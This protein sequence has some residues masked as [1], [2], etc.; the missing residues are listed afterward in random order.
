[1]NCEKCKKSII[2]IEDE[3]Y[4]HQCS[5]CSMTL[6]RQCDDTTDILKWFEIEDVDL[7][8]CGIC[9]TILCEQKIKKAIV[10]SKREDTKLEKDLHSQLY[11]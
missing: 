4:D 10:E 2:K 11:K 3:T 8:L 5:R 7:Y 6:C 1:M 9:I